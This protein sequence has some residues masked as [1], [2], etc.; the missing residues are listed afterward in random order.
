MVVTHTGVVGLLI[1]T[2][3]FP[4]SVINTLLFCSSLPV[5]PSNRTIALSEDDAGHVVNADNHKSVLTCAIVLF[6]QSHH[7]RWKKSLF[8]SPVN[9]TS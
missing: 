8:A 6:T 1:H 5:V 9:N 7:L 3:R 2:P 4:E